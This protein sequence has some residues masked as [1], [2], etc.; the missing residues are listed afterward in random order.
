MGEVLIWHPESHLAITLPGLYFKKHTFF[1][2]IVFELV[3]RKATGG[4]R[5]EKVIKNAENVKNVLHTL[6]WTEKEEKTQKIRFSE[7]R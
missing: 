5:Q 2:I 6:Y 1:K 7:T 4:G 3:R